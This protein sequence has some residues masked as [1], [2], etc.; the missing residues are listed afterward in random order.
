MP[1]RPLDSAH[2]DFPSVA[3][4]AAAI[5]GAAGGAIEFETKVPLLLRT[6][7]DEVIDAPRTKR[8]LLSETEKTE[9]TYL[10]TKVEILI[11]A[12]LGFPKGAILDM[13]IKGAEVDIKNTMQSNWSIPKENVGRPALLIRS[14]ELHALCDVGIGILHD[15]YLR[16]G[17]N[18]DTKR[19]LAAS[20]FSDIWWLLWQHPYP[21]NFW[22]VLTAP[23]RQALINAGGGTSRI[24]ALFELV[25]RRP[26]SRMQV[27][28]LAQQHD[29]M[30][31]IRRNGGARDILA[32]KSIALLSG[33]YDQSII[34]AMKLGL[35]TSEEFISV[36]PANQAERDMLKAA[37][38]ID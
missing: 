34:H 4:I 35:V 37:G 33:A 23:Q 38:H 16:Q 8:F 20:H 30:K 18:R 27:Q 19:G 6:A 14:S 12:F 36:T 17:E 21:V 31:R 10:G 15:G 28:A 7:V 3:P 22:Q 32:P 1:S 5:L 24:A 29:Y 9:K 25:Q 2:P 26:I 13:N 11:R